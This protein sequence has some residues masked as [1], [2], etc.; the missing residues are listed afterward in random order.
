MVLRRLYVHNFRCL[1]NFELSLAGQ[2]SVL[3]IG[4]NGSGKSTIARVLENLQKIGRGTS[5]VGSLLRDKD[6]TRG[7]SDVPVRFE[8]EAEQEGVIY[9]YQIAF[10]L[11]EGFKELRVLEEKLSVSG[12]PV[13]AREGAQ[14]TLSKS[15]KDGASKFRIDGH[16][17]ALPIVEEKSLLIFRQSLARMLI[18]RPIPAYITGES[19]SDTLEPG[20]EVRDFGA[21]FTGLLAYSPAA[22]SGIAGY[23]RQVMPD[24]EDVKNP[25][26]GK[27]A[28]SPVV[29]FSSKLGS[30]SVAFADL[31]D[32]EKCF[33]ICALVLA[34][35]KAS[36]NL[37]CFW[38]EPDNHLALSEVGHFVIA[39]RQAFKSGSQLI[40]TSHNPEAIR[41][42]SDEN[43]MVLHRNSHLEP[44][45]VRP[46]GDLKVKGD[47]VNAL[48]SD[49]LPW[50]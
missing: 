9:A 6:I 7:H 16:M 37:L 15:G 12:K 47:L 43:T 10:D 31:S 26:V 32:G 20:P 13:C 18:L 36:G 40:A 38:D 21:W 11:P 8:I 2:P 4:K 27:D 22:Y 19:N 49:D 29:Q 5:R 1:E 24:L 35:N 25:L 3:L 23:L 30:L 34:A 46:S 17:V 44:T 33:M 28:R 50:G 41:R 14:V 48:I 42:F 39:L 45:V